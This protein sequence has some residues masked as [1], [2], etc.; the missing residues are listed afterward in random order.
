MTQSHDGHFFR[1]GVSVPT[2]LS[3]KISLHFWRGQAPPVKTLR[4]PCWPRCPNHLRPPKIASG[5]TLTFNSLRP[6]GRICPSNLVRGDG[7]HYAIT[8][9]AIELRPPPYLFETQGLGLRLGARARARA[10]AR[11]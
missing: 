10:K 5:G 9:Y 1:L 4:G 6:G 2:L 3:N 8:S 7:I 11:G